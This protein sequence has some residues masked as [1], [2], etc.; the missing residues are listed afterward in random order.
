MQDCRDIFFWESKYIGWSLFLAGS[1]VVLK[2]NI[3][4][5]R[6]DDKNSVAEKIVIALLSF[7][8]VVQIFLFVF[9]LRSAAYEAVKHFV[10]HDEKLRLELGQI[11]GISQ[12]PVAVLEVSS[13]SSG[14]SGQGTINIIVKVCVKYRDLEP[15]LTKNE[16]VDWQIQMGK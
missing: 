2:N 4:Y 14:E 1:I 10:D 11:K 5:K 13:S 6:P 8:L 12:V 7:I 15:Q 3:K 16:T 9:I